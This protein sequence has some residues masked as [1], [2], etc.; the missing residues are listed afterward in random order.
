MM[1]FLENLPQPDTAPRC[2]GDYELLEVIARGGMGVVYKARQRSLNR[3]VALKMLLGGA[4]AGQDFKQRFKREA[5]TAA[6]LNHPNIVPIYEVG[7]HEGQLYFSMEFVDGSDLATIT[8]EQPLSWKRAAS[9]VKTVAEAMEYAHQQQVLHRDLK[10]ANILIG[11][12][13]R[14]RITDF[15]LARQMDRDSSLTASTDALGT[16]GYLPPEQASSE[17]GEVGPRSDLYALG[18]VLYHILT[19]RPP[20]L[21]GT[22]ADALRQV[23]DSEPVLVRQLN[24]SVPHDLETITHKC[25]EKDPAQRYASAQ[26]LAD[27]L[28]RFLCGQSVEARPTNA[29]DRIREWYQ[30]QPVLAG[31]MASGV[32]VVSL[33]LS[34]ALWLWI[35]VQS[36]KREIENLREEARRD[37]MI[38]VTTRRMAEKSAQ[39]A[40]LANRIAHHW[41]EERDKARRNLD[42]MIERTKVE[43]LKEDL[44]NT[45]DRVLIPLSQY[46]NS[47]HRAIEIASLAARE[48]EKALA[49]ARLKAETTAHQAKVAE[50]KSAE[51]AAALV[52]ALRAAGLSGDIVFESSNQET[53]RN[54][55]TTYV[56]IDQQVNPTNLLATGT[57]LMGANAVAWAASFKQASLETTAALRQLE[58]SLTLARTESLKPKIPPTGADAPSALPI[59]AVAP[60]EGDVN[61]ISAWQPAL[62]KGLA[63]ML[64]RELNSLGKYQ[65][66][67]AE[68]GRDGST[69]EPEMGLDPG[70]AGSDYVLH[71]KVVRLGSNRRDLALGGFVPG[72]LGSLGAKSSTSDVRID[73]RLVDPHHRKIIRSGSTSGSNKGAGFDIEAAVHGG[74]SSIGFENREFMSSALGKA[75]TEA[76]TNMVRNLAAVDLP[77]FNLAQHAMSAE[78]PVVV[79]DR[80]PNRVLAV[81]N[82]TTLIISLGSAQGFKVGDQ[83]KL[84]EPV[85][86]KDERGL[87]VRTN[88]Q[89]AGEITLDQ[90]QDSRSKATYHG[91][92]RVKSGWVV[93]KQ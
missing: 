39:T 6:K 52:I 46:T 72:T 71:C 73:W 81:V 50:D 56:P 88:E 18:A 41:A 74:D 33:G 57:G 47:A 53:N 15:G 67:E 10:P 14:P 59:L 87:T 82:D 13:D 92:L 77:E 90:V 80:P 28:G 12:D 20:F 84:Y 48:W 63:S 27:D 2:V 24:P 61:T 38:A 3:I 7:E 64:V 91:Q 68:S 66:R 51:K 25:L 60:I 29:L 70:W 1:D 26:A 58:E 89:F 43:F 76:I 40:E 44:T 85:E 16:P 55:L 9:Y 22:L 42:T 21:A 54:Y 4:H 69:N 79:V 78:A 75:T 35:E 23:L 19:S 32:L 34:A 30:R 83:L 37:Q 8:R 31:L 62:G 36:T 49:E 65:V 11:L 86:I 93:R 17:R 5:E 45:L